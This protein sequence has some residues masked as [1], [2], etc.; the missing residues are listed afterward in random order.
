[1][2]PIGSKCRVSC[3]RRIKENAVQPAASAGFKA[4]GEEEERTAVLAGS[5]HRLGARG[6]PC[7]RWCGGVS[8]GRLQ[9]WRLLAG[10]A[11]AES[12][13]LTWGTGPNSEEVTPRRHI[14]PQWMLR[15]LLKGM[16]S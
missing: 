6:G 5:E 2:E 13:L 1:M 7:A 11:V 3:T 16:A 12:S 14:G 15:P 10:F 4:G 9:C 8:A